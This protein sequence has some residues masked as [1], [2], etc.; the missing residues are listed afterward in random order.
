MYQA[1]PGWSRWAVRLTCLSL[2]CACD[3]NAILVPVDDGDQRDADSQAPQEGAARHSWPTGEVVAKQ[4]ASLLGLDEMELASRPFRRE[5]GTVVRPAAWKQPPRS[6]E[7]LAAL[8][9]VVLFVFA[10][11]AKM[12]QNAKSVTPFV[13]THSM[14][15]VSVFL[16]SLLL[17]TQVVEFRAPSHFEGRR[18]LSIGEAIYFMSVILGTVG[19]GDIY[20]ADNAGQIVVTLDVMFV[21]LLY[22]NVLISQG[23]KMLKELN[24]LE[25]DTED[26]SAFEASPQQDDVWLPWRRVGQSV[27][28]YLAISTIGVLFFHYF[29]GENKTWL[30]SIH[31][32]VITFTTVGLGDIVPATGVGQLFAAFWILFGVMSFTV[33]VGSF[34]AL[35]LAATKRSYR[36]YRHPTQEKLRSTWMPEAEQDDDAKGSMPVILDRYEFLKQSLVKQNLA[37]PSQVREIENSFHALNEAFESKGDAE[38]VTSL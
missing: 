9:Y 2:C 23:I 27:M 34:A 10:P 15:M 29:P 14:L 17:F 32:T 24:L 26:L 4:M 1:F 33:F 19:Y 22:A 36:A 7:R 3:V 6:L 11:V 31:M 5:D 21:V 16:G 28:L 38:Q 35:L 30:Q 12:C 18:C 8:L 25:H 13:A 37:S 20:P